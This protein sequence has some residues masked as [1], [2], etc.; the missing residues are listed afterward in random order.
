MLRKLKETV[1]KSRSR[2]SYIPFVAVLFFV[3]ALTFVHINLRYVPKENHSIELFTE[4]SAS[5]FQS[6]DGMAQKFP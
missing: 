4:V 1:K 3:L 5:I 6:I 2:D